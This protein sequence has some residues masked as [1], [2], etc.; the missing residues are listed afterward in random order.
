[1]EYVKE[2]GGGKEN[3]NTIDVWDYIKSCLTKF[4][5]IDF[6]EVVLN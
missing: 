1:M 2:K 4:I 3:L 6:M 5:Y